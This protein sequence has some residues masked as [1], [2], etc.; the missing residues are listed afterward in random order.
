MEDSNDLPEVT[1]SPEESPSP[2]ESPDFSGVSGTAS[3]GDPVRHYVAPE[4]TP[5]PTAV[6]PEAED[7]EDTALAVTQALNLMCSQHWGDPM[8]AEENEA[9]ANDLYAVLQKY[10]VPNLPI[11]EE[12]KL[13]TTTALIVWPR[14]Q[15]KKAAM[16]EA[17]NERPVY[18]PERVREVDTMPEAR[19]AAAAAANA[20]DS[21]LP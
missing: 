11:A 19:A 3:F 7:P 4:E 16:E 1:P 8:T 13:C 5:G 9:F 2:S 21:L 12:M 17:H 14:I 15:A 18:R 10:D 20:A 6:P